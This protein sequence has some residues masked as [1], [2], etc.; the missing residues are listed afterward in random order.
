MSYGDHRICH[1]RCCGS[2]SF[3]PARYASFGAE[4]VTKSYP[5]FWQ[6]YQSLG[7]ILG[8]DLMSSS[9]GETIRF[10]LF[11]PVARPRCGGSPWR[12]FPPGFPLIWRPCRPFLN[13]RA[14]GRSPTATA[15]REEDRPEFLSG[16]VGNV[17]CGAPLTA[18]IPNRD[19][20][21]Q[22]YRSLRDC[23]R[24]GHGDYTA[25]AKFHGAQD[26]AG[27]GHLSGRLTAPLCIAGGICLQLLAREGVTIAAHIQAIG[28]QEDLPFDP[29]AVG[30]AELQTLW[31]G[32][33]LSSGS[34]QRPP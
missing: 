23:P 8:G 24:P 25:Q 15:R 20:H 2:Q 19:I 6:D 33:S 4:A 12:E 14:P 32:P 28:D 21:P 27:G 34:R 13:R 31:H 26:A 11:W 10:T 22:D 29:V 7:G 5:R 16:L 17:T 18:V 30:E 1:G 9:Y 3:V